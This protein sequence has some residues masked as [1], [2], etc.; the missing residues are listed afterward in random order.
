MECAYLALLPNGFR[1][2]IHK[3]VTASDI[4]L[5]ATL[6][7]DALPVYKVSAFAQQTTI[8]RHVAPGAY[9]SSLAVATVASL[10]ARL[11]PPGAMITMLRMHFAAPVLVGTTLS[12]VVTVTTWDTTSKLYWLDICAT[13]ADG[14]P[15]VFGTA[16]LRPHTSVFKAD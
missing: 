12:V 2:E 11:P 13:G 14:V 16:G 15:V 4:H 1:H 5:W 8:E 9:L 3:T 6:T 10:A 7:G